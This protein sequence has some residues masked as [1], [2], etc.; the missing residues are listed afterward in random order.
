MGLWGALLGAWGGGDL[1]DAQ[2]VE[3][4]EAMYQ[5]YKKGFAEVPEIRPE[6]IDTLKDPVFVDVRP[7]EER[8]VGWIPGSIDQQ[9]FEAQSAQL[10]GRPVVTYCTIGARSGEYAKKLQ[11]DGWDVHNLA[12]SLLLWTHAGKPLENADGPTTS[13]HT[14]GRRWALVAEGYEAVW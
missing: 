3:K 9:T 2:K 13:V 11:Q 5:G 8:R 6:Q 7:D 12:G 4:I 14:Y 10:A 1:T